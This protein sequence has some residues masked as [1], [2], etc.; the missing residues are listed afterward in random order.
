M[1]LPPFESYVKEGYVME[2]Q[3]TTGT[4]SEFI[5][6][7]T[8]EIVY[9]A[10]EAK[11]GIEDIVVE[12]KIFPIVDDNDKLNVKVAHFK[13]NISPCAFSNVKVRFVV[14]Q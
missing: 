4:L 3:K 14:T 6:A 12:A 8:K 11:L 2:R 13:E 7:T 9:G 5:V 10:N 1:V